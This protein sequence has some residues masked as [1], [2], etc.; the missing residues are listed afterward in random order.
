MLMLFDGDVPHKRPGEFTFCL[1]CLEG[2]VNLVNMY[3]HR[4]SVNR[5]PSEPEAE[6]IKCCIIILM[7]GQRR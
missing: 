2:L 1:G 7:A 3:M 6:V 4:Y 5:Y